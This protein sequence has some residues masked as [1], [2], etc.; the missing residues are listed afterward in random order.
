VEKEG[1]LRV[2]EG[3]QRETEREKETRRQDGIY[4]RGSR[5]GSTWVEI[6]TES[7]G[8]HRRAAG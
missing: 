7:Y 3:E 4:R 2:W 1:M 5:T 8:Y 6:A